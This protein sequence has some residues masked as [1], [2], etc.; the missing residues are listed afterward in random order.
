MREGGLSLRPR[1]LAEFE[2]LAQESGW[3]LEH[4]LE[5]PF[6]YNVRMRKQ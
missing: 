5:R 2:S 4:V 3:E 1:T 6:S